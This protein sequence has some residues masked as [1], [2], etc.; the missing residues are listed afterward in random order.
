MLISILRL[1]SQKYKIYLKCQK[2][3]QTE[4]I[5]I[6][7]NNGFFVFLQIEKTWT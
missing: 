6:W 4:K 7:G 3:F 1:T 5:D 2:T